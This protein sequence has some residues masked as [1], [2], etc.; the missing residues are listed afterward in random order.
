MQ[1]NLFKL[2]KFTDHMV[3]APL[4]LVSV[5]FAAIFM[6]IKTIHRMWND[7]VADLLA[8]ITDDVNAWTSIKVQKVRDEV[9][10]WFSFTLSSMFLI[11]YG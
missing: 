9:P 5:R 3:S 8:I 4:R 6:C 10:S 2:I 1:D 11:F 7:E